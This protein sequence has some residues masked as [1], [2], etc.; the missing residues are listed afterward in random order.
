MPSQVMMPGRPGPPPQHPNDG[1]AILLQRYPVVWQGHL[2]LK[3]DSSAVQMHFVAGS[4][5]LVSQALPQ[6]S[7]DGT[8]QPLRIAQRMRLEHQQLDGV[9]RRMQV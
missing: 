9:S 2:A 1:M 8:C 4:R 6:L 7:P 5:R 3:N